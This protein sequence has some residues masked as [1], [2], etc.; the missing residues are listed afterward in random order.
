M[1]FNASSSPPTYARR[2]HRHRSKTN[3]DG[4]FEFRPGP[5]F[6]QRPPRGRDQPH[7]GEDPG[8]AA[9][10]H[11]GAPGDDRRRDVVHCPRPFLVLATQNPIEHEGTYPLPEAKLDRFMLS[12]GS[13]TRAP[14][15]SGDAR[16]PDRAAGR[17][18]ALEPI[19]NRETL[20]AMQA[21]ARQVHVSE[22]VGRY[23]VE[24]V[25]GTRQRP[26]H[27]P[28]PPPGSVRRPRPADVPVLGRRRDV[29]GR[30]GSA[31]SPV[32]GRSGERAHRAGA[33]PSC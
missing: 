29:G 16:A 19:V 17:D 5:L 25:A 30:A 14:T 7:A 20:L 4:D 28:D 13:A 31:G 23:I 32:G 27:R 33:T 1:Q 22:S 10:G 15:T 26:D 9:R 6:A 2:P 12:K 8:G 11:A 18:V 3:D 21:A 24:L